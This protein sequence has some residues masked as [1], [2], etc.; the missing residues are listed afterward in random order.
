MMFG[1]IR[2]Q[3]GSAKLTHRISH[4]T[5]QEAIRSFAFR[6]KECGFQFVAAYPTLVSSYHIPKLQNI[7]D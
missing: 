3:H 5:S 4:H 7:K 6:G 2:E 1:Q